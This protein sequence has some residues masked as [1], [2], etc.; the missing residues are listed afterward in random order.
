MKKS[1]TGAL[2]LL[3]GAVVA[4]SQSIGT[5]VFGNYLT[6]N[7][8][9]VKLNGAAVGGTAPHTGTAADVADGNDW[10]V[11]LYGGAGTGLAV[12]A[13]TP[14]ILDGTTST[15]VTATLAGGG[16]GSYTGTWL[17]TAVGDITVPGATGGNQAVTVAVAAWYNNNGTVTS[18]AAAQAAGFANGFSAAGSATTGG[19]TSTTPALPGPI[20]SLGTINVVG[21][22]GSGGVTTPEPSTIALGIMGASAFLMRLRKK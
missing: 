3:A 19:N 17:S 6:G 8:T 4:H 12:S 22:V 11:E 13:L 16:T 9:Y 7:Y 10:T 20:P 21:N 2:A 5:V 15:P 1:I 18:L 14:A